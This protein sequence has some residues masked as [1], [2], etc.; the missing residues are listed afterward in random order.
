VHLPEKQKAVFAMR[1]HEGLKFDTIATI[2][3]KS[4]GG[5]KSNYFHA[6]RKIEKYLK[7]RNA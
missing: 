7:E 4:V 6:L 2:L 3:G 1:Y 5:V